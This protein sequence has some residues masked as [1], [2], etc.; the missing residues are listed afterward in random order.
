MFLEVHT[1]TKTHSWGLALVHVNLKDI[2]KSLFYPPHS[3]ALPPFSLPLPPSFSV[4]FSPSQPSS[5]LILI[6]EETWSFHDSAADTMP[7]AM[8]A[9]RQTVPPLSLYSTDINRKKTGLSSKVH[10]DLSFVALLTFQIA[11]F[12]FER[13]RILQRKIT[14]NRFQCRSEQIS[15]NEFSNSEFAQ[16]L[17]LTFWGLW[18]TENNKKD[19]GN[20]YTIYFFNHINYLSQAW[21][22]EN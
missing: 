3:V 4:P 9:I 7:S 20:L 1:K 6:E 18:T 13:E 15:I 16:L 10:V 5:L 8:M 11:S 22:Q 12:V 14:L 2:I 19:L 21:P 17:Q